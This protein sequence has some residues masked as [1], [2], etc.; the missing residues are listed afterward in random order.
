MTEC[1]F[2]KTVDRQMSAASTPQPP[3]TSERRCQ[4]RLRRTARKMATVVETWM[5]GQTLVEVSTAQTIC[6]RLAADVV[7]G[8]RLGTQLHTVREQQIQQQA[9]G[10][11]GKHDGA[12]IKIAAAVPDEQGDQSPGDE[13]KPGAIGKDK[14]LVK[15]DQAVQPAVDNVLWLA[16]QLLQPK[17]SRKIKK[18]KDQR[19]R[20]R[21]GCDRLLQTMK[22]KHLPFGY[23]R[24]FI[25]H[26]F[27]C[28][29]KL[30]FVPLFIK[31]CRRAKFFP[32]IERKGK[33]AGIC[34]PFF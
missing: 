19:K 25:V 10:H 17:K 9:N 1:C 31:R 14:P 29:Y 4:I 22:H 34:Q 20:N 11:A 7:P 2:K 24:F 26:D 12:Q 3:T 13:R 28:M 21:M 6:I 18:E 27:A 16:D 15:G 23:C 5:D 32:F 8:N 33:K 30:E